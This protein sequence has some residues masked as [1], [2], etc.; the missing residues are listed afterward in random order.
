MDNKNFIK[1]ATVGVRVYFIIIAAFTVLTFL[2]Q[3][4][5]VGAIEL[6]ILAVLGIHYLH[7]K[8]EKQRQITHYIEELTFH[9]DNATRDTMLHFPLPMLMMSLSGNVIWHNRRFVEITGE[10]IIEKQIQSVFPDLAL[11]QILEQKNNISIELE[12]GGKHYQIVGNIADYSEKDS[13]NYSVVLYFI[14]RTA[15]HI[16]AKLYDDGRFV[17]CELMIDNLDDLMKNTPEESRAKLT[18]TIE[19]KIS[20]WMNKIGGISRK[21]EKDKYYIIFENKSLKGMI[22][23]KF[24]I[25]DDVREI[26]EGNKIPVTLSLGIGKGENVRE[27][28]AFAKAAMDMALGRGGDQVVVKDND[29]FLFFGGHYEGFEKVTKVKPR[30]VAYAL[31]ELIDSADT[32]FIMGHKMP[33]P[34]SVGAAVG[35]SRMVRNRGRNVYIIM[36]QVCGNYSEFFDVLQKDEAYSKM[37][38]SEAEA[39]SLVDGNS[40]LIVVDTHNPEIVES[41]KLLGAVGDKVLIDHHRRGEHFIGDTVLSYHEPYASSTCEMVTEIIQYMEEQPSLSVVEA[42]ALYAG[43]S[44]DTKYFTVKTGVRTFEAASFLRRL[45]VDTTAVKLMFQS[46]LDIYVKRSK[47]VAGAQIYKQGIAI[48]SWDEDEPQPSL[49][50]SVASD[51]LLNIAGI[52]TSFVLCKS[53]D[54][55]FISGRSVGGVNVQMILEKLGGGG[56]MTVAGAQLPGITMDEAMEKLKDAIDKTFEE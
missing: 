46:D 33:D 12:H 49:I 7:N 24:D 19:Q 21:Y 25:L 5:Y 28:D 45:G 20:G 40:L 43:L 17:S 38:I 15:E 26:H 53:N 34:D 23:S 32:V 30:V 36:G 41:Q 55:I 16:N 18:A 4:Y 13:K 44:I 51:E 22:D 47:I 31:R 50:A 56:H 52:T 35:L 9:L 11:L 1:R 10:E 29:R 6:S 27:S 48:S 54:T 2:R 8:K 14:D 42:Q 39:L 37:F 3:D